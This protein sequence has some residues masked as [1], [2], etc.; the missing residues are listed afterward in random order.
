M[1]KNNRNVAVDLRR[2]RSVLNLEQFNPQSFIVIGMITLIFIISVLFV[3]AG[4]NS[5][6][7]TGI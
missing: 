6:A 3:A 1:I 4:P 2:R 7:F 5:N